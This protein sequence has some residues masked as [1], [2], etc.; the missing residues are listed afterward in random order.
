MSPTSDTVQ[1]LRRLYTQQRTMQLSAA[2]VERLQHAAGQGDPLAQY[3]YGRWLYFAVPHDDAMREA[4]QLFFATKEMVADSLAVYSQM[5]RYG[6]TSVTHPAVMDLARS[7][8]L[9]DQAIGMGSELAATMK[10]RHCMFGNFCTADPQAAIE[11]IHHRLASD[12][13]PDPLWHCLLGHAYEELGQRDMA[14]VQYEQAIRLGEPEAYG[15]L[16]TLY[17]QRGNT[18]LYEEYMEEGIEKGNTLCLLYQADTDDDL[19]DA[20]PP[21]EQRQLHLA[22]DSRLERGLRLCDGACAYYLWL[23]HFYGTLG[24]ARDAAKAFAHL[25]HGVQLGH[26]ACI[27]QMASSAAAG[28]LP[29]AMALSP[30]AIDELRLRA[31]RYNPGD[32]DLLRD[33]QAASDPAFLLKHKAELERY[34]YPLMAERLADIDVDDGR[35]DAYV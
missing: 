27:M 15:H 1:F 16:A 13:H 28:D 25:Q 35:Y 9:L 12:S 34:W 4:E 5:L 30:L 21:E 14:I 23:H 24:F 7:E 11:S 26:T 6:E 32:D 2:E 17:L 19:Y 3:G 29:P 18:A 33:L 31:A 20:L 8:E 10:A 22:V